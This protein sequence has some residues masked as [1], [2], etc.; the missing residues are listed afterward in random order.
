MNVQAMLCPLVALGGRVRYT[1]CCI[2]LLLLPP[3]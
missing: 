2:P 3:H 1:L